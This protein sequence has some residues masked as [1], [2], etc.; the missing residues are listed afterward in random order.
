MK[1][2]NSTLFEK[3]KGVDHIR[4]I[5]DERPIADTVQLIFVGHFMFS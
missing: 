4:E 1:N 5:C 3:L 2:V